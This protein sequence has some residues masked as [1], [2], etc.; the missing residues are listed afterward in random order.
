MMAD[1]APVSAARTKRRAART[2]QL[3][4]VTSWRRGSNIIITANLSG[5]LPAGG[6]T[7]RPTIVARLE[8]ASA[9]SK[10]P[11]SAVRTAAHICAGDSP[12]RIGRISGDRNGRPR[13]HLKL[14]PTA[15][16]ATPP[17]PP[18]AKTQPLRSRSNLRVE[19]N[20]A[21]AGRVFSLM[22]RCDFFLG[23]APNA[24]WQA[25]RRRRVQRASAKSVPLGR[26]S[27]QPARL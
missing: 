27:T 23:Q 1:C 9:G 21:L 5:A 16:S 14:C 19:T 10:F 3:A 7:R 22:I 25:S 12:S 18:I 17:R 20:R 24:A 4:W 6:S 2:S 11:L 26:R 8:N 15:V 13:R